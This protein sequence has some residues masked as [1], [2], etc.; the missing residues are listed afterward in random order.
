MVLYNNILMASDCWTNF[1]NSEMCPC[2]QNFIILAVRSSILLIQQPKDFI[3]IVCSVCV[4]HI[5][6]SVMLGRTLLN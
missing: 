4:I 3:M 1:L 2:Y 6:P 5:N